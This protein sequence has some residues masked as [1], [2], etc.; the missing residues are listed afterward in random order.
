MSKLVMGYWD[1]PICG[2]KEIRGDITNCPSC[3]R[4]R[5]DVQFYVKGYQGESL[6][7]EEMNQF[8]QLNDQKAQEI[9]SNPDWYCSFCNSL[10]SDNAQ[11]C[12]NCGATRADSE[13][14][15]FDRLKKRQEQEAAELAA[16]GSTPAAKPKSRL[17]LIIAVIVAAIVGIVVWM[18]SNKTAGDLKV[19]ALNWTR[20][21]QIEAN[22]QYSESDWSMPQG[23]ELVE[24]KQEISGYRE[25]F[26]HYENVQVQRSRQVYDHDEYTLKDNGNG[27]FTQVAHP[28]Y[29]TEYYTETEKRAVTRFCRLF[30]SPVYR[31]SAILFAVVPEI[32]PT[33]TRCE[34]IS[35]LYT[36]AIS[37]FGIATSHIH[38]PF[39]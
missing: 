16:Q 32:A 13:A 3:G 14:N 37:L 5:G 1:C 21:I 19:T 33:C 7:K 11:T 12:G 35:S 24:T 8:E 29:R 30:L 15:Y 6:R 4:A 2:N 25:V 26:D 18:N 27:T 9:G 23:A 38:E 20:V 17:L 39:G 10:N 31:L 22:K 36:A 28:V 34:R